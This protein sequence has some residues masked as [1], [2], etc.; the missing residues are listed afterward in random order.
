MSEKSRDKS[1]PNMT[2]LN[3][4]DNFML[5]QNLTD[6]KHDFENQLQGGRQCYYYFIRF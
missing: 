6:I 5:L 2:I 4:H 3:Q 1:N